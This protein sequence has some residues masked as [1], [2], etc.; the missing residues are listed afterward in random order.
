M[1]LEKQ[2]H[3]KSKMYLEKETASAFKRM[4]KAAKLDGINLKIV[5]GARNY[6]S[7]KSIWERK[8]KKNEQAG[9]SAIEYA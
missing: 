5:S 1:E 8:F 6:Y 4:Y 3:T 7:Q 9:M 2:Y